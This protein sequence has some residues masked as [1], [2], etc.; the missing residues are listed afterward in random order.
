MSAWAWAVIENIVTLSVI[1]AIILG[2]YAMGGG[3]WGMWA[4]VLLL[5]L[6]TPKG[7]K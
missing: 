3:L 7:H 6:N 2:I 4:F 1:A 5:N